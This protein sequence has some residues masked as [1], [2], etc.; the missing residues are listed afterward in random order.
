MVAIESSSLSRVRRYAKEVILRVYTHSEKNSRGPSIVRYL[1]RAI[2]MVIIIIIIGK[3]ER[4]REK[5]I[6]QQLPGKRWLLRQNTRARAEKKRFIV[7]VT[8]H[9]LLLFGRNR[10]NWFRAEYP[11]SDIPWRPPTLYYPAG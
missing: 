10:E 6:E 3:N 1:S 9:L 2:Y 7:I 8:I 4:V 5:D 11:C